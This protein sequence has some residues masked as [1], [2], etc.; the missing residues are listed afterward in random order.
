MS[1]LTNI[2]SV[3]DH[4][5][6]TLLH[7]LIEVAIENPNIDLRQDVLPILTT[8]IRDS[9]QETIIHRNDLGETFVGMSIR[10]LLQRP[11]GAK[12]ISEILAILHRTNANTTAITAASATTATTTAAEPGGM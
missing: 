2:C 10:G 5:S 12:F 4:Y 3:K 7:Q 9:S 8:L 1:L 6:R 11:N